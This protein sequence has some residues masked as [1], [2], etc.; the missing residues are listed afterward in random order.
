[1]QDLGIAPSAARESR[2]LGVINKN[3]DG[4]VCQMNNIRFKIIFY[5]IFNLNEHGLGEHAAKAIT[6]ALKADDRYL[7]FIYFLYLT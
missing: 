4:L 5:Q 7:T 1:M 2:F 6:N 3:C